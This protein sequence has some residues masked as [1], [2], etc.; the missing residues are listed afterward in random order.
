MPTGPYGGSLFAEGGDVTYEGAGQYLPDWVREYA[1]EKQKKKVDKKAEGGLASLNFN[2]ARGFAAGGQAYTTNIYG[3]KIPYDN[4]I[5]SGESSNRFEDIFVPLFFRA[6]GGA[7]I[8]TAAETPQNSYS[9]KHNALVGKLQTGMGNQQAM[10]ELKEEGYASG[11]D[12]RRRT[13][14]GIGFPT[15][16]LPPYL[17]DEMAAYVPKNSPGF[18]EALYARYDLTP[19]GEGEGNGEGSG[20]GNAMAMGGYLET[21]GRVGDG[22]SDDIPATIDGTQPAALSDGEFVIPADVVSHL[23]NGS[24]D[25]GAQQLYDMMD[26]IRQARTGTK[27]QGKEINAKKMLPS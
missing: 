26:R 27:E 14:G 4:T 12:I 18:M 13:T 10:S 15:P 1:L 5:T 8:T 24:S 11:G 23:G 2:K 6:L 21:G 9:D 25:A 22:M 7:G 20:E 19:E 3:D 16:Y 17:T